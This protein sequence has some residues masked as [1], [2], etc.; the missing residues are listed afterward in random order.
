M[1]KIWSFFGFASNKEFFCKIG[2][3]IDKGGY[4]AITS[5]S[6]LFAGILVKLLLDTVINTRLFWLFLLLFIISLLFL[7]FGIMGGYNDSKKLLEDKKNAEEKLKKLT[8]K[9][10]D[11]SESLKKEEG[12]LRKLHENLVESWLKNIDMKIEMNHAERVSIYFS[13]NNSFYIL[14]RYSKNPKLEKIHTQKFPLNKGVLSRAW[15][16]DECTE[17]NCP[18]YTQ[19][20]EEYED[21]IHNEYGYDREKIL[22]FTMRS[23]DYIGFSIKDRGKNIGVIIFESE[24]RSLE[25]KLD[26]IKDVVNSYNEQ[27]R[28]LIVDGKNYEHILFG[29]RD[30]TNSTEMEAIK[31]LSS[32]VVTRSQYE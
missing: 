1:I 26:N 32:K 5:V 22:A 3:K 2:S 13:D 11:L 21:H 7:V 18:I 12:N 9:H 27:I 16:K 15:E 17:F 4:L 24:T 31:E 10:N 8:I 14:G 23:C 19:D 25:E 6:T 20:N 29:N 30:V 28:G